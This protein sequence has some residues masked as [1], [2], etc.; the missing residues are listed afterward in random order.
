MQFAEDAKQC[1]YLIRKLSPEG[2]LVND[3]LLNNS[4]WMS[5]DKGPTR[6]QA[7]SLTT[8]SKETLEPIRQ[9]KPEVVLIGTGAQHQLPTH[10][11]YALMAEIGLPCEFMSTPAA[12][13]TYNLL[14]NDYRQVVLAILSI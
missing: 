5:R 12:C 10:P 9:I 6:W 8:L 2:I 1:P 13:R 11:I 4:F 7:D 14:A 3:Q